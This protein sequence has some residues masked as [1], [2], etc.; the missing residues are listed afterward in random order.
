MTSASRYPSHKSKKLITIRMEKELLADLKALAKLRGVRY[1][2][3][4]NNVLSAWATEG[5]VQP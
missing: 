4:I 1:Q 3:L 2:T 5:K